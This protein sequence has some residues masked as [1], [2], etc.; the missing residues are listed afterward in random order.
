[1]HPEPLPA[2][3]DTVACSLTDTLSLSLIAST[4][5]VHSAVYSCRTK[6]LTFRCLPCPASARTQTPSTPV[7]GTR[8]PLRNRRGRRRWRR[9]R[10][11]PRRRLHDRPRFLL[12]IDRC[13][14]PFTAS[15]RFR[16]Q[17]RTLGSGI[18]SSARLGLR[19]ALLPPG[20]LGATQVA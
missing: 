15:L 10:P 17:C 16:R 1:M 19:A 2:A 4:S 6:R 11:H 18:G 14:A 9:G 8:Y 5:F 7:V 20:H 3:H 13:G 12:P